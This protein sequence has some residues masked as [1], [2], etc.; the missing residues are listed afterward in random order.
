MK[1][2]EHIFT[3]LSFITLIISRLLPIH[4]PS[5]KISLFRNTFYNILRSISLFL[6][7]KIEFLRFLFYFFLPFRLFKENSASQ[8]LEF[9]A[10]QAVFSFLSVDMLEGLK[11]SEN[12]SKSVRFRWRG[13]GEGTARVPSL[14]EKEIDVARWTS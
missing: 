12:G 9:V 8:K 11:L 14:Q 6:S 5:V 13:S 1:W 10:M 3:A 7:W 4:S 2:R